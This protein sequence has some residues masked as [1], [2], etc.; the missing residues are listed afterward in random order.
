[1]FCTQR[2]LCVELV[3]EHTEVTNLHRTNCWVFKRRRSVYCAVRD[4][5][6]HIIQVNVRIW[7]DYMT[8]NLVICIYHQIFFCG[9]G[10]RSRSYGRTVALRLTVQPLWWR[11]ERWSVFL[12]FQVMEH[13][14]GEIRST[15]GKFYHSATLST[16]N[17]IWTD[18]RSNLELR[19]GRPATT[20]LSHGTA[21][22]KYY[23]GYQIKKNEVGGACSTYGEGE[24]C[25]QDLG[26]E[27]WGKETIW[28]TQA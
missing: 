3:S 1:M 20:R 10:A 12:F 8:R 25:I 18:L 22:T 19:G 21:I 4:E 27:T 15:R 23:S 13:Q 6:V 14:T 9:E 17:L 16:T 5:S 28:K 2:G 11:W 7:E 26:G 24:R